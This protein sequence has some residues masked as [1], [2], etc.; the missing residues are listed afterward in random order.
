L[1][2]GSVGGC[3][4]DGGWIW[5]CR[6]YWSWDWWSLELLRKGL[7]GV[8]ARDLRT[9]AAN[10]A[11]VAGILVPFGSTSRSSA[12]E[13]FAVGGTTEVARPVVSAGAGGW[14]GPWPQL[15]P[16]HQSSTHWIEFCVPQRHSQMI[17]IQ[18]PRIKS[19]LPHVVAGTVRGIPIGSISSVGLLQGQ[20]LGVTRN[21]EQ[22]DMIGRQAVA[23]QGQLVKLYVLPQ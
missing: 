21:Y 12:I 15:R 1:L 4:S 17:F 7:G 23:Q 20:G 18:W 2:R 9:W 16:A 14:V 19:P 5:F 22:M 10:S 8:E 11:P 3:G 13:V 6:G